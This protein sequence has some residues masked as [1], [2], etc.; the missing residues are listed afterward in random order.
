MVIATELLL[1]CGWG[2][3][4]SDAWLSFVFFAVTSAWEGIAPVWRSLSGQ[5]WV[6][7]IV[8]S[9]IYILLGP[10]R[11][12][13][14]TWERHGC[15]W[16]GLLFRSPVLSGVT[17]DAWRA[18]HAVV[19]AP[20]AFVAVNGASGALHHKIS[21]PN[22]HPWHVTGQQTTDLNLSLCFAGVVQRIAASHRLFLGA[23]AHCCGWLPW[24]RQVCHQCV[25]CSDAVKLNDGKCH[26]SAAL[27]MKSTPASCLLRRTRCY[28]KSFE[29]ECHAL[30]TQWT[31]RE[32]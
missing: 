12:Q 13:Q 18:D 24:L 28:R 5:W 26:V 23:R 15:N 7:V 29:M 17:E 30:C 11:V 25:L 3:L 27:R 2:C 16:K 10:G 9:D 14:A 22:V 21:V 32:S 31:I 19:V 6:L 4:V 1:S 8:S 20:V